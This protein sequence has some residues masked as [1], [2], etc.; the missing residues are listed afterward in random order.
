M[1]AKLTILRDDF[2]ADAMLFRLVCWCSSALLLAVSNCVS[3]H[4]ARICCFTFSNPATG[5]PFACHVSCCCCRSALCPKWHQVR[6]RVN[7]RVHDGVDN[8]ELGVSLARVLKS[9]ADCEANSGSRC[10][11]C[12]CCWRPFVLR[13][14]MEAERRSGMLG[15]GIR[16]GAGGDGA[17]SVIVVGVMLLL[18]VPLPIVSAAVVLVHCSC[19]FG[20]SSP[21]TDDVSSGNNDVIA[22]FAV[23]ACVAVK[24][25]S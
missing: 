6:F 24:L 19:D 18:S 10:C 20:T 13:R 14:R 21:S 8:D 4:A 7:V 22:G 5:S 11:C 15:C 17:T 3:L 9:P 25:L 2:E 23:A 1:Y 16:V 12:C